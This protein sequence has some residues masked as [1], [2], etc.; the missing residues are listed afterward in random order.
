M[1]PAVTK[2]LLC[3][4]EQ[5]LPRTC[6]FSKEDRSWSKAGSDNVEMQK[7]GGRC[8]LTKADPIRTVRRQRHDPIPEYQAADDERLPPR[9]LAWLG[10]FLERSF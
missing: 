2:S 1:H 7:S 4:K 3:K 8:L 6:S 10:L 5:R 9:M